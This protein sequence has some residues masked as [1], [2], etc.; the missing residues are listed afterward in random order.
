MTS[1][2]VVIGSGPNGLVAANLLADAGWEVVVLE[3][4]AEPGGTV[5]TGELTLPGYHHD[6]F[7]AFYPL[8]VASPVFQGLGLEDFGLR[9]RRAPYAVA[10]PT[11]DG[12]CAVISPDREATGAS[13]DTYA[14][15]DGCGWQ[16]L[17]AP[18]DRFG[19]R[20]TDALLSPFPPIRAGLRLAGTLGYRG[21]LDLARLCL[22]PARRLAE[23]HFSGQGGALLLAGNALHADLSPESAGSG[24]FGWLLCSLAQTVGFP[25]PEGG[26]GKLTA[27]LVR[28]LEAKGGQVLCNRAADRVMVRNERAVGVRIAGGA[29]VGARRAVL[30][31][32]SAPELYSTLLADVELPDAIQA[33]MRRFQWDAGTV[34]VDWALSRPV[35]WAATSAR[36]AGTVH[37]ADSVDDLS[38]W[39]CDLATRT[40]PARPFLLFGQQSMTDPSR[41]PEGTETAWAYTHVPR[42]ID[43]DAGGEVS[44]RWDADDES[45][46]VDRIERRVE[47]FAPGFRASI[48]GRHVFTPSSMEA[49]D[50]NLDGGAINGGTSQLHQQLLFRPLPGLGR[51]STFVD[52]LFLASASAHPGGGVHGACGSNAARAALAAE[53]VRRPR[54]WGRAGLATLRD[55]GIQ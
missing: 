55:V 53:R 51:P 39:S 42:T 32:V 16:R 28:R 52:G 36:K 30:A 38:R 8:A 5:R 1:D 17:M 2:A 26:A 45:A 46:M 23:E 12:R 7:S 54:A 19:T 31:D 37:I 47:E 27:A 44:G 35:P 43:S 25:V 20:F 41:Q 49:A 10:N 4:Q 22:M 14:A 6:L 3:A 15:G 48:L 11:L 34:K 50:A 18:W 24:L 9:W 13:L 40:L 33:D 29:V 21:A